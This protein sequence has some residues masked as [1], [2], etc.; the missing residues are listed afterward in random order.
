MWKWKFSYIQKLSYSKILLV[1]LD[2]HIYV[3]GVLKCI[4]GVLWVFLGCFLCVSR[5]FIRCFSGVWW[6]FLGCL[7]GFS[8]RC[9]LGLSAVFLRCFWDISFVLFGGFLVISS[10]Y[11]A[12][13]LGAPFVIMAEH[14]QKKIKRMKSKMFSLERLWSL[15]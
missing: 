4:L 12:S 1:L 7:R 6:M 2:K 9:F 14:V 15:K 5:V 10:V 8:K 11:Q 13:I 3:N